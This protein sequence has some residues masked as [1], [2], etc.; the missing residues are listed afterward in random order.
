MD[1][2]AVGELIFVAASSLHLDCVFCTTIMRVRMTQIRVAGAMHCINNLSVTL[3]PKSLT[4]APGRGHLAVMSS[5]FRHIC[6]R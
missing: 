1:R 5:I 4:R 3:A 2:F 6:A